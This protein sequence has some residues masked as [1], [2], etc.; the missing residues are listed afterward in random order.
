[1]TGTSCVERLFLKTTQKTI[2]SNLTSKDHP[3]KS[4][5][6]LTPEVEDFKLL[7]LQDNALGPQATI[8]C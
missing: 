5:H 1:M 8:I 2:Q 6:K 4:M 3:N 7:F